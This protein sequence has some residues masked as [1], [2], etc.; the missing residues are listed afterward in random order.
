MGTGAGRQRRADSEAGTATS[1]RSLSGRMALVTGAA[2]G[3]GSAIVSRFVSDG[4]Y[5]IAADLDI[6][7]ARTAFASHSNTEIAALDVASEDSCRALF[8]DLERRHGGVDIVINNAGVYPAQPFE[9]ITYS[10][11]RRVLAINLDSVYLV[12]RAAVPAMKRRSWGRIISM[13]SGTV[14]LGTAGYT[15]YAAA[16]AG[17]IGFTRCLS[18]ELGEFGITVNAVSPGLTN[19][20]TVLRTVSPE[21]L[22]RRRLQRPLKRHQLAQDVVG[23]VRF[24]AS[25]DAAFITGQTINVDGGA[26]MR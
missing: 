1:S 19:T 20:E 3:I 24:L 13:A 8:D 7:R 6:E 26:A 14:W 22:E 12:T 16:K 23:A 5:V 11:W 18:S 15:H 9:T 2:G 17:I 10:E 21:L 4:A 25:E